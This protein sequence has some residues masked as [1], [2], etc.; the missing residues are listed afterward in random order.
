M[1]K[2]MIKIIVTLTLVFAFPLH[3]TDN[4]QKAKEKML[5]QYV[6]KQNYEGALALLN[7]KVDVNVK[8]LNIK[9]SYRP[10]AIAVKKNDLNMLKLLTKYGAD[11]KQI[12]TYT[13][14]NLLNYIRK[15]ISFDLLRYLLEKGVSPQQLSKDGESALHRL[16]DIFEL[17]EPSSRYVLEVEINGKK[18][19][20]PTKK[21]AKPECKKN[22]RLELIQ[23]L[24]ENGADVNAVRKSSTNKGETPLFIAVE[25]EK[26]CLVEY[27][28]QQG[29]DPKIGANPLLSISWKSTP[30]LVNELI[31]HGYN[32]NE[33][34]AQTGFS[35]L[36]NLTQNGFN[37][38]LIDLLLEKGAD[39][40]FQNDKGE[41][42]L[43]LVFNSY[44][45]HTRD[46]ASYLIEKGA[47]KTK[48][49]YRNKLFF[50]LKRGTLS[51]LKEMLNSQK[52]LLKQDD[53]FNKL[54]IKAGKQSLDKL[55]MVIE[56]KEKPNFK[57]PTYAKALVS[58]LSNKKID[59]VNYLLSLKP[60]LSVLPSVSELS[61]KK[62][63]LTLAVELGDV[64]LVQA[65]VKSGYGVDRDKSTFQSPLIT[66]VKD[67]HL[68]IVKYLI[69]NGANKDVKNAFDGS[70][71][72]IAKKNDYSEIAAYLESLEK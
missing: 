16:T 30:Y 63:V 58:A 17:G 50:I 67:D 44:N 55:K 24:V 48:K 68:P 7:E 32:L 52:E 39:I 6:S 9:F 28:M 14:K 43:S 2:R 3:A 54:V 66:A 65:I 23:L 26:P 20:K 60:D 1:L 31:N 29:A 22:N 53:I 70:L 10:I 45:R 13:K 49:Y 47:K 64:D 41:T 37:K 59:I 72:D 56:Q 51:E 12:D 8:S 69:E 38:Q 27:F 71:I 46:I 40:N 33:F 11:L 61:I 42:A 19:N 36:A 34:S 25:K 57:D 4:D 62:S 21:L 35:P 18:A 5:L 15:N